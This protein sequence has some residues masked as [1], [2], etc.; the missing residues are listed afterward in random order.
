[1]EGAGWAKGE[2]R[3]QDSQP[4]ELFFNFPVIWVTAESTVPQQGGPGMKGKHDHSAADKSMYQCPV[5]KYPVRNDKYLIFRVNLK[6][7][8]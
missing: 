1:M 5:Y 3:L 8:S 6:C 7:E 2:G 4:K